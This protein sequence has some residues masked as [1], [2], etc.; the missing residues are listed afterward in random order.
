MCM[1]QEKCPYVYGT[2]HMH[3]GH[4]SSTSNDVNATTDINPQFFYSV[5]NSV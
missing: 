2:S 3:I 4:Y 1:G 5:P